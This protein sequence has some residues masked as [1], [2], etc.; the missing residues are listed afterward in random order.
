MG[1]KPPEFTVRGG[2]ARVRWPADG[3]PVSA[4]GAS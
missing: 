1:N 3:A 4:D 2:R